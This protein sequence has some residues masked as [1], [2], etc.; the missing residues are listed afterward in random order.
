MVSDADGIGDDGEGWIDGAAGGEEAGVDDVEVVEIVGFAVEVEDG[1]C[2]VG[3][4]TACAILVTDAFERYAFFEV[5]VEWHGAFRM[6]RLFENVDPAIFETDKRFDVVVGVREFDL[7]GTV[8]PCVEGDAVVRVR[9]IF[10]HKPPGNSVV[11]HGFEDKT[12]GKGRGVALSSFRGGS[13][14]WAGQSPWENRTGR[15]GHG[16]KN[17]WNPRSSCSCRCYVES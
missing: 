16:S 2:G 1:L 15:R 10:G 11:F 17:H 3:A 12:G 5:R 13:C 7:L 4:E 14:R 9:K 8:R 6:T